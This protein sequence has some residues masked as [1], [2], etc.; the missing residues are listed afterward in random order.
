[1]NVALLQVVL[2]IPDANSLK[3]KRRVVR[4]LI[5][6]IRNEFPVAAAEIEDQDVWRSAVLGFASVSNSAKHA[7][8][9]MQKVLEYLRASPACRVVEHELET[10]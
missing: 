6:R 3:D 1:M 8:S 10:L 9:V 7:A 5:D 4:G 2:Q